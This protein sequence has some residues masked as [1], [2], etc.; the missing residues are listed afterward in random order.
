MSLFSSDFENLMKM[1][2]EYIFVFSG[3][4]EKF[5]TSVEV[6]DVTRGIWREFLNTCQNR[7]KFSAIQLTEDHILLFGGKDEVR[8]LYVI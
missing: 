8:N 7:T 3:F 1:K 5:L 4:N 6:F 2:E